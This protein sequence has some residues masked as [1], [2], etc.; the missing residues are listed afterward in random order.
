M[1]KMLFE[2]P[3]RIETKRLYLRPYQAGDG[4]MYFAAGLRNRDHLER[5]EKYNSL[6][7]LKDETHAEVVVR[8]FAAAWVARDFFLLGIFEKESDDWA[9]QVYIGPTNWELPEF[10]IGYVADADQQGKGYIS[11]AVR[12]VLKMLFED[13]GAQRVRSECSETNL[14]SIRVL[15]RCGF[16]REG[17]LRETRLNPDGTFSGDYYY[18]L[19]RREFE[20]LG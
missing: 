6:R 7:H 18:G 15:E 16:T 10:T 14:R 8:E 11:E 2:I 4:P 13:A 3:T 17:H 19:L 5:Y 9:G 12:G 20:P 1:H